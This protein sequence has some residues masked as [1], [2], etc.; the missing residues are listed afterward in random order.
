MVRLTQ[1]VANLLNNAAKYTPEGG[2]I[3]VAVDRDGREGVIRVRDSGLGIP[4]DMLGRV[5]EMFTQVNRHLGR[6]QGG[7]GIGLTLVRRLVEM[8][9]GTVAAHS[10]GDGKGAEFVV[11]LPLADPQPREAEGPGGRR[12]EEAGFSRRVLVV[13]DNVDAAESLAM[14]LAIGGHEVATARDGPTG[15]ERVVAFRPDVMLLDLGMPGMDGYETARR[16]REMQE[17][18]KLVLVALTGWGQEEDRRRTNEA[19]FDFHMV[20][21]VDPAAL[22]E[23]LATLSPG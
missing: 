6:S 5:F 2:R 9:G 8:H 19:G 12:G 11:R 18:R 15:L 16:V 4:A 21:P 17:G 3:S 20:K 22:R 14:L 1:V 23:L 13:D 7:L 10:E